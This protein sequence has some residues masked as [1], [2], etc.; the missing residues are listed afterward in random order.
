MIELVF[1]VCLLA[2]PTSCRDERVDLVSES[3]MACLTQGQFYAARWIEEHPAYSLS[4][5]RCG[6][7]S[8][9]EVPI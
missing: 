2:S 6:P 3:L 1:T 7:R 8:A 9:R 4:R 5:W